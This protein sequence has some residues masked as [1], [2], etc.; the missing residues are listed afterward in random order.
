MAESALHNRPLCYANDCN[1]ASYYLDTSLNECCI[2]IKLLSRYFPFC[3][4]MKFFRVQTKKKTHRSHDVRRLAFRI[5]TVLNSANEQ[6]MS[7]TCYDNIVFAFLV[8]RSAIEFECN[9]DAARRMTVSIA[10]ANLVDCLIKYMH[11]FKYS[12]TMTMPNSISSIFIH[13]TKS[14]WFPFSSCVESTLKIPSMK[15]LLDS[16]V[17]CNLHSLLMVWIYDLWVIIHFLM[18]VFASI[19]QLLQ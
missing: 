19:L 8:K 3:G 1:C 10:P 12:A 18:A 7:F 16:N 4:V 14:C 9:A 17:E 11:K 2:S 5:D 15:I 6:Q 13:S